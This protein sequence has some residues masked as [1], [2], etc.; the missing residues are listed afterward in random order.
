[1]KGRLL[2]GYRKFSG[3]SKMGTLRQSGLMGIGAGTWKLLQ[4]KQIHLLLKYQ[5]LKLG[6]FPPKHLSN[7]PSSQPS[8][9]WSIHPPIHPSIHSHQMSHIFCSPRSV[10]CRLSHTVME[11]ETNKHGSQS[12]RTFLPCLLISSS[13]RKHFCVPG[14]DWHW[15]CREEWG[16]HM[17]LQGLTAQGGGPMDA[18]IIQS[19]RCWR[20][21]DWLINWYSALFHGRFKIYRYVD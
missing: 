17:S 4:S 9:T 13:F 5:S 2:Q 16:T 6:I 19:D 15:R 21:T 18:I 7:H 11:T 3:V 12:N 1:M 14:W 10:S 20:E 8:I